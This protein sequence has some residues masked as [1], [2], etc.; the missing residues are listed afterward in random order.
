MAKGPRREAAEVVEPHEKPEPTDKDATPGVEN[1][2]APPA[3]TEPATLT[4]RL[5]HGLSADLRKI[6]EPLEAE[7]CCLALLEPN[8]NINQFDLDKVFSALSRENALRER[9]VLLL[10]LSRG[11]SIEPAYQISKICKSFA[12]QKFVVCVPRHA[13]S[14]ATLIALGADEIHMGPLGHLGPIDP[15]V[16]GLP[17]LGVSQALKTVA[18]LVQETPGSA[19]MFARYLQMAVSIEQI[20]FYDRISE[21]AEQYAIRL[22]STKA[23]V[24]DNAKV[25]AHDLVHEYK[26]HGFVIDLEEAREHL[27]KEWVKSETREVE[28]AEQIYGAFENHNFLAE[29]V[30]KKRLLLLGSLTHLPDVLVFNRR[31]E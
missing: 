10:L 11:G 13:K 4:E 3:P 8:D 25:I 22:L 27:G 7:Y 18:K 20:G 24:A 21:S 5:Q 29:F 16:G 2:P 23:A 17:A 19:E 1:S 6:V 15:Q 26:D 30:H 31:S 14:A 12:K 28:I 9:N